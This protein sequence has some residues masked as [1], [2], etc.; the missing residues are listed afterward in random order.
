[1]D[2]RLN[3]VPVAKQLQLMFITRT[4]PT[5]VYTSSWKLDRSEF[6]L[7]A[8]EHNRKT[9]GHLSQFI[10]LSFGLSRHVHKLQFQ[11]SLNEFYLP[12]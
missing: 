10:F 6:M 12:S 9:D 7:L 8:E 5:A 11:S 4:V 1:M 3:N 2:P